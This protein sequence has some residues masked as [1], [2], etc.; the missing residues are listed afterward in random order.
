MWKFAVSFATVFTLLASSRGQEEY[1]TT[2]DLWAFWKLPVRGAMTNTN[3]RTTC[4]RAGMTYPCY[5]SGTASCT[6]F[7]TSGC[8]VYDD[9]GVSCD[10]FVVLSEKLCGSSDAWGSRCHYL[11]DTF[12][13][14]PNWQSDDSAY[15][16]GFSHSGNA[17]GLHGA[18]YTDKYALCAEVD[19]CSSDPCQ[20]G[21]VCQREVNS[22]T[23]QCTPGYTGTFCETDIDDCASNP[24]IHGNC[25]DH[26]NHYLCT[27]ESGWAGINCNQEIDECAGVLC[28]NGGVCHDQLNNFACQCAPGFIGAHCEYEINECHSSPCVHALNCIDG[29]NN[30]TCQCE[31]GWTGHRCDI[32]ID[33]CISNPC[34]YGGT[35]V[36]KVNGY[37]C[38]CPKDVLGE[39]CE[40]VFFSEGCYQFSPDALSHPDAQQA[41]STK[42]GHLAD[43]KDGQQQSAI[44]AGIAATTGVSNWL[45]LKFL[46]A[47]LAYSDGSIASAP[48][49]WSSA[50][51]ASPCDLCVFLDSSDG[52]LAKT[53][54]CTERHSYVCQADIKLCDSN[55]CQNGGNCTSCFDE[56]NTFC[57]CLAGFE[58]K[59]C[60]TNI[61][62]CASNPCQHGGRCVDLVDS[63]SCRCPTGF[64]GDNCESDI[65]WCLQVTCPF[66][67]TCQNEITHFLCLA[68][69]VRLL[70]PYRCSSASCPDG[71]Y[72]R[73]DGG[74]SFSC[75]VN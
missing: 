66:D 50:E 74:G 41:C 43:V 42:N 48:L 52:Y 24:C 15:G 53:T 44:A 2:V 36:D 33:D 27:C 71:M 11:Y 47:T 4:E 30:F 51:P 23:C 7:W 61:N 57:E 46:P 38:L 72:C 3:V 26:V 6:H 34:Y 32:D 40:T 37:T 62:E 39:K 13:Y 14:I 45:G 21:A 12:V 22:F 1:L 9:A 70:E 65:D 17:W 54:P 67:W 31:P 29:V 28:Q 64:S 63:Y 59:Y 75:W 58:G 68:P 20:N 19:G 49:Q 5:L 10:T 35:C 16:V 18:N 8:I 60:E 73:E 56:S 25:V 55:V 69:V